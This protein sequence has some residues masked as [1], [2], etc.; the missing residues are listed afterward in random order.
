M[1]LY[2]SF[3]IAIA[4]LVVSCAETEDNSIQVTSP[5]DYEAS[6]S[7]TTTKN[8]TN[9]VA[10][11]DFWSNKMSEDTT[12]VGSLSPLAGSYTTIFETTGDVQNLYNAEKLYKK[13]ISNS[14]HNKD[15]FTRSLAHNYIAQHRFKE[16]KEILEESY[17]GISNK[18]ATEHMLFDVYMELGQYDDA[19]QMLER[20]KN[21]SDY[22][23]LIRVAKW[24][25]YKG[26][27][28]SAIRFLE[29]ARDIADSRKSKPLR[30]WTYTN[31]GDFYGHAGRIQDA[32]TEYL[33][34]LRLDP[35]NAYAKKGIA[36][37]VYSAEKNTEE[38]TKIL[39]SVMVHHKVPDYYLLKAEMAAYENNEA[40]SEKFTNQFLNAVEQGAY[41]AMYNAYLIEIYADTHP[42]KALQLAK[43]EVANRATPESYHLLALAQLKSS[44]KQE[45]LQTIKDHV[46]GKTSEPMA[47]YHSALV[48]KANEGYNEKL[49]M[50][51]TELLEAEFEF[52]PV[53]FKKI[54]EL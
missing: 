18:R 9:A 43:T 37:I 6:L 22:N 38:A 14:A 21:N 26:D 53:L 54:Q 4:L 49:K 50:L 17:N 16:A 29:K 34:T 23:Y 5:E 44:M 47:L 1:K 46:E 10:E 31:L 51:K 28:D 52:G 3:Y 19:Y 27:L 2:H 11:R 45:A 36:W 13:G 15:G 42:E 20:V 32:Y 12:G 24:S 25:D 48:Y 7:T 8:Y 30:I 40:E 39:D 33:K 35:E 41:G